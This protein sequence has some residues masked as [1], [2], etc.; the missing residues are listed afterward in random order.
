MVGLIKFKET[1]KEK[2]LS[3][4]QKVERDTGVQVNYGERLLSIHKDGAYFAVG[5]SVG[6]YRARAVLLAVG[7]RGT[8]RKLG[9]PGEDLPKVT[10][11]LLD[12]QQYANQ[13]VLVVGGGDSA[14]EAA[15]S[16]ASSARGEGNGDWVGMR[17]D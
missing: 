7:R 17:Y 3:F 1:S 16:I 9:V 12:P 5:T 8:P 15:V 14:I 6:N 13:R 10:Y 11:R 4:W 2:L